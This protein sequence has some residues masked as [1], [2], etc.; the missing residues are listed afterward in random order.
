[1]SFNDFLNSYEVPDS[2]ANSFIDYARLQ[3][4]EIDLSNYSEALKRYIKSALAGQLYSAT[5]AEQIKNEQD[6][7]ITKIM[8]LERA[9]LKPVEQ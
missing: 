2:L 4:A 1:M 8:D 9:R 5:A 6:P 3:Q 7:M